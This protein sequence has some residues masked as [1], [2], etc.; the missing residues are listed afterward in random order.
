MTYSFERHAITASEL[1]HRLSAHFRIR[2]LET[3]EPDIEET[4][5]RIYEERLL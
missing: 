3:H 5:P 4:V 2:D 1:I